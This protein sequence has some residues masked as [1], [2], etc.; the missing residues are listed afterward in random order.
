M[1][2]RLH[3]IDALRSFA[4]LFGLFLHAA[5]LGYAPGM[6][7]V[8][9]VSDHFRMATFFVVSGFFALMVASR[10]GNAAFLSARAQAL[11]VPLAAG[12]VLLVPL[13]NWL[14]YLWHSG[15][16]GFLDYLAGERPVPARGPQSWHLHLW[17]LVSLSVYVA[18]V[19][20]I[21]PLLESRPLRA[22]IDRLARS[23]PLTVP[24]VALI[25]AG[26]E[27]ATRIVWRLTF[28]AALEGGPFAWLPRATL[29]YWIYFLIG[30]AAF[31]HRPLF[32]A[33]HRISLVTFAAG[34]ALYALLPR[35][36]A[37]LPEPVRTVVEIA[38]EETITAAAVCALL[39]VFRAFLSGE[40]IWVARLS[41]SVYTIYLFHFTLIYALALA[42][43]PVVEGVYALYACVVP[44]TF[45]FGYVLHFGLVARVPALGWLF[46]GKYHLTGQRRTVSS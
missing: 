11:L 24:L 18:A 42:L 12:L 35:L 30:M 39:L 20:L 1:T 22:A 16:V 31:A 37:G 15:P 25:A 34:L 4:M 33:M 29:G 41:A 7:L 36:P 26:G 46:N 28:E 3:Y 40:R 10:R 21:R 44:L 38:A 14:V 45:G 2:G 9:L 13:T 43:G 23:G 5:T 6:S 19:P 32:E 8:S 17:F 27:I